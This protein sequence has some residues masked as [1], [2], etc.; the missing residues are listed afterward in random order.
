MM[1]RRTR[2]KSYRAQ[3]GAVMIVAL[4]F[5][6]IM[7]V[8]SVASMQSATLQERMAGNTKDVNVAFQAAEAG[9]REAEIALSKV[10]VGPFDGSSGL[11]LSCPDPN[12]NRDACDKP[13][14]ADKTSEG[15]VV[16]DDSIDHVARQPEYIIEEMV[17]VVGTNEVL[18]SDRVIPTQSFYRVTARGFGASDRSMVVLSTTYKRDGD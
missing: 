6:L 13:D 7:T 1:Q 8:I 3:Q 9:L 17:S 11:F 16:L 15:W 14:W 4:V 18:D 12:D 10:S 2:A 5:T